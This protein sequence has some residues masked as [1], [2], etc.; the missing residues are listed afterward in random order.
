MK[1]AHYVIIGNGVAAV[2]CIEGIR[3]VDKETPIT[4]V[5]GEKHPVYCRPLISYYLEGATDLE[6]MNYRPADFYEANGCTVLYGRKAVSLDEKK[7]QVTLDDGETLDFTAVCVATG[8]APFVPPMKGLESVPES[9]AFMTLDDTLALER[10]IKPDSRVLIV[11]A[12][13]I[14][15]KCAEGLHG[16]VGRITVCDLAPRVLS[17]ILDDECASRMQA[18]LEEN[19]IE[20]L[21]GDT[22]S[23]FIGPHATM[24]SG[25]NVD[26]DILVVAVGVRANT[27]LV[28]DA[29][30][31]VGRG[32]SVD[33][34]LATTLPSVYAAGDC[35]EGFDSSLGAKRVLAILPNAYMQGHCAGV[36]MAGGDERFDNAVAMNS[37]GFFGLHAITAGS[38][39]T[40]ADGGEMIEEK[41]STSLKRM[42]VR[43][44]RLTGYIMIGNVS[45]A[46]IYT[47]LIRNKT[48]LDEINFDVMK[49]S[50]T[51]FAYSE[52]SRRKM[53]GGVV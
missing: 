40:E 22:V 5:S 27:A 25:A 12:G 41:D 2:G 13:L 9:F 33:E 15:L 30:G 31:E 42:F 51:L 36:N 35:T 14:G 10:A 23:E 52:K 7:K 16:R 8:S 24:Q 3:S 49:L 43:D 45:R 17:S 47:A 4:V 6:K 39:F 32:I 53:L 50:P 29:G 18:R 19:G 37:I 48:P 34:R 28:K 38:Y 46:G 1:V 26:F 20:F 21:L 11:G 44:G